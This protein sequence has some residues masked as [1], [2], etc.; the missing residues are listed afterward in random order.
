M[1]KRFSLSNKH[2]VLS[3]LS[4]ILNLIGSLVILQNSS[5][6]FYGRYGLLKNILGFIDY[7]HLGTRYELDFSKTSSKRKELLSISNSLSI[8][9]GSLIIIIFSILQDFSLLEICFLFTGIFLIIFQNFR[10]SKRVFNLS[11]FIIITFLFNCA[12][13]IVP[14]L[15]IYFP[16]ELVLL[17]LTFFNILIIIFLII[18]SKISFS[19]NFKIII[20]QIKKNYE[21]LLIQS[22]SILFILSDRFVIDVYSEE[23]EL[24]YYSFGNF[25][26]TLALILPGS[27]WETK[28]R[29]VVSKSKIYVD[30]IV[31][32]FL[33][34]CI[35]Y[36]IGVSLLI[37]FFLDFFII[38]VNDK[39]LG[40]SDQ[41]SLIFLGNILL[42]ACYVLCY[43]DYSFKIKSVKELILFSLFYIAITWVAFPLITYFSFLILR[44]VIVLLFLTYK[45]TKN[46]VFFNK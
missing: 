45:I 2:I 11:Q 29:E 23:V 40:I 25:I 12:I 4:S 1:F 24:S 34:Q 27:L 26:A 19:F 8:V 42:F 39:Y 31:N 43:K 30:I 16:N 20:N 22:F 13:G 10:I 36:A 28:L 37:Y 46:V 9:I 6:S 17:P 35:L 44:L 18:T 33:R 32:K 7:S 14:V 21:I 15:I 3:Y 38:Y 5:L 41:L